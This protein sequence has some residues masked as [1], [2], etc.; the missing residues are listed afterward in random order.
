MN[1][2]KF[3]ITKKPGDEAFEIL[4]A[5]M[6]EV[7]P[8]CPKGLSIDDKLTILDWGIITAKAVYAAPE[9]SVPVEFALYLH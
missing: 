3:T 1:T 6:D 5:I 7:L 8:I 4:Q 2:H 9:K